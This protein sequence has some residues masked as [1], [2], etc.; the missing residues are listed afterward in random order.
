MYLITGLGNP[1]TRYSLTRHN[2]GFMILDNLSEKL[3]VS[4]TSENRLWDGTK[5]NISD[6]YVYLMKPLTYMNRCGKA[7]SLFINE[8]RRLNNKALSGFLVVTDDF[9]LPLGTIRLRP[10]GSDGGHN[11]L[12]SI[13]ENLETD[14]FPRMRVGI[15]SDKLKET[16]DP[17]DFV[18]GNFTNFEYDVFCSLM[19][20][21]LDCVI[22]FVINGLE[23]AMNN[24]NRNYQTEI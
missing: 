7:V 15:G 13:I 9:N 1:G 17:A 4:F 6:K 10:R 19:P 20:V 18:L 11:G 12:R 2:A 5:A 16:D 21:Y 3:G 23:H 24:F 8:Y 14:E 22:D